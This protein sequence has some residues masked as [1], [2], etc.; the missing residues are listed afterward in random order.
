MALLLDTSGVIALLS[1]SDDAHDACVAMA[2]DEDQLI[3]PP[4]TL[5]EID[6]WCRKAAASAAFAQF[7]RD[8][9]QGAYEL[10]TL[11]IADMM[12][13]AEL[14][15][16]YGDLDLGIVDA[17]VVALSERLQITRVLTLDR[18]D[19]SVV[20]PRHCAALTLVPD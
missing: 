3:V 15:D 12:R 19:F 18:R 4:L 2:A 13:S 7:T 16:T 10:A 6:Y 9:E 14:A 17:S 20:R 1:R 5:V 11:S 8:I